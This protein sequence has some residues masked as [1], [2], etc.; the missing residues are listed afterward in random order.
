ML[1]AK[2]DIWK[3]WHFIDKSNVDQYLCGQ[4]FKQS[5]FAANKH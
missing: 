2:L 5:G 4:N 1:T 3:F